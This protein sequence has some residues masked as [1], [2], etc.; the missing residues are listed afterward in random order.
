MSVIEYSLLLSIMMVLL[1]KIILM[2]VRKIKQ[3]F[4]HKQCNYLCFACKYK[5]E[6]DV[7][8]GV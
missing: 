4:M 2:V 1:I 8:M 5:Y 6:C 3:Y 7:F